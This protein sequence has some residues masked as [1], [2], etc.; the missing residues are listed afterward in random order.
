MDKKPYCDVCDE[1]I[2][3]KSWDDHINSEQHKE[4]TL[5]QIMEDMIGKENIA[6]TRNETTEI[7]EELE[8]DYNNK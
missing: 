2:S 3:Q 4:K 1:I 5:N 6:S 8:Q 7:L